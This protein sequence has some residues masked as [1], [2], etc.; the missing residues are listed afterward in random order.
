MKRLEPQPQKIRRT[1]SGELECL[2]GMFLLLFLTILLLG[3]LQYVIFR[4]SALYLE[5]ALAASNL[6]SAMIDMKEYGISHTV[7][8]ISPKEAYAKYLFALQENLQLDEN[9][10][11]ANRSLISGRVTVE[12]YT[13]YNVEG[14][15][16]SAYRIMPDGSLRTEQGI[17]GRMEA[18]NGIL[19]EQPGIYSELSFPVKGMFGIS[20]QAHKGKLVDIVAQGQEKENK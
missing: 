8:I 18:P 13:I 14:E 1:E 11:C 17:L 2:P 15:V 9:W 20:V 6:A 7:R 5:D 3:Q 4:A 19:I 12:N 16:V 10:E